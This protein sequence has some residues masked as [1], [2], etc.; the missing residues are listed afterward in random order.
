MKSEGESWRRKGGEGVR[1]RSSEGERAGPAAYSSP[2]GDHREG[3]GEGGAVRH[4]WEIS[5]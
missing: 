4:M 1:N 2:H 3:K 5:Q